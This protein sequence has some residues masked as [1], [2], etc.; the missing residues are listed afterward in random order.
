MKNS[1]S[2]IILA[3]FAVMLAAA[4]LQAKRMS[5][6]KVYINPG[7][8]GYTSNDRPIRIHPFEQND[9]N[10]YWES[11]SNLYKGLH[12]YHILDSLGTTAYL[13]R[14][15]NT[16]D[17][18]RDLYDI[19]NE[20]NSLGVDLFFSI[21]SNAG[22][23][24]NY[25][26]MLYRENDFDVPRYPENLELANILGEEL[27]SNQLPVWTHPLQVSGD[28]TFYY[29]G[30]GKSGLG[31]LRKLYTVGLL[32]EGSMHEHRPEAHR[33]MND[34]YLWLEAWHFVHSIMRLYNTEDR[35]VTGNVA[36]VVYDDH[37]LRENVMPWTNHAFGR[38]ALAPVNG[39]T[40]EL[41][42]MQG[43][44]VQRRTTDNMF[45]GIFVF[46][47][48][49]PGQ[50]QVYAGHNDFHALIKDVT[51]TADQVVYAEMPLSLKRDEPL[52][53]TSYT[54][55]V[56][57]G[58]QVSA[59][60]RL[61]FKFN[62]DVDTKAFENAFSVTPAVE[63]YWEYAN[64]YHE[65]TFI[66][67]VSFEGG[68]TYTV[69]VEATA[70]TP[71]TV[72]AHPQMT[73][74]LEFTFTTKSRDRLTLIDQYPVH[75]AVVH[76][77]TPT[78]EFRFDYKIDYTNVY[79]C[80]KI[81]DAAGNAVD[82]NK[83]TSKFNQ[84]SNNYG[85]AV[86]TLVGNLTVGQKY[87]ISLSG[88]LR[89]KEGLPL[90]V[91]YDY[92]V[93]AIDVSAESPQTDSLELDFEKVGNLFAYDPANTTGIGNVTPTAARTTGIKLFGNASNK[94]TYKFIDSHDGTVV[95][96]YTGEPLEYNTDDVIGLFVNGDFNN[97]ELWIGVSAG[98]NKKY[99]K[100][101]DLNFR[102]WQYREVQLSN[103]EQDF[104]PFFLSDIKLVQMPSAIT[105]NGSFAIDNV[106]RRKS[107]GVEDI[108]ADDN[109]D[110]VSV[111]GF[112]GVI[113]VAGNEADAAVNVYGIDG[114]HVA[115]SHGNCSINA[116][117][118]LY[119]VTVANIVRKIN[120]K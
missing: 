118:G 14:T 79:D 85:N 37:N 21:H 111:Q 44:V 69:R 68:K 28:V 104:C 81:T 99:H 101:C 52:Q 45:N 66:P 80:I 46:R 39:A 61:N 92:D 54:P 65:A 51:V 34:D 47:N 77:A 16:E 41:R 87:H 57:D 38:N 43:N 53:I 42:D 74:P 84:L 59:A 60:T 113:A 76:Y 15:K 4:P 23:S 62:Y 3:L 71:D 86:M 93:T 106:M 88:D 22:E 58:E 116:A 120:V 89:D 5:D 27:Y 11:K 67:T 83:R 25:P 12:M 40:V 78:F 7:H 82:F 109:G 26:L 119:I 110:G 90:N 32:S 55:N 105:Q 112:D 75:D 103:L 94:F 108:L 31:V 100:L 97:H 96:N 114:R 56:A 29:P 6:L 10:G 35:F 91:D 24:V 30:W 17:D 72:C 115:T 50:Y 98:T 107:A 102:G 63:G 95:W 64:S 9:S 13:S 33:L 117:K 20:A 2:R 18:D 49:A 19:S 48:V 1:I 70:C 8:G 36:G 73:A